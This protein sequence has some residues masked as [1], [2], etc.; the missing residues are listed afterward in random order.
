MIRP[1]LVLVTLQLRFG[2]GATSPDP[3]FG[4]DKVKHF[5]LGTLT[6]SLAY[7][8]IRLAGGGNGLGL[9]GASVVTVAAGTLKEVQDRTAQKPASARDFLWTA[10]GGAT[11]SIALNRTRR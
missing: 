6:Q 2:Q 9:G 7:G 8:G 10:A 4:A 1:V 11:A 3:W 5:F